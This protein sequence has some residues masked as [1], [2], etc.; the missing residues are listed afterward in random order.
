V[1]LYLGR[2]QRSELTTGAKRYEPEKLQAN[3]LRR[4]LHF[5]AGLEIDLRNLSTCGGTYV[6]ALK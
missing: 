2:A 6:A 4:L 5:F 1:D 3:M